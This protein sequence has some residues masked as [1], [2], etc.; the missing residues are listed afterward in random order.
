MEGKNSQR[1]ESEPNSYK[2][3]V[4]Y[5]EEAMDTEL[6]K[7]KK[8]QMVDL[9]TNHNHL[10]SI[11]EFKEIRAQLRYS[12]LKGNLNLIKILLSEATTQDIN[13]QF[14]KIDKTNKTA[15]LFKADQDLYHIVVPRTIKYEMNDHI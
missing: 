3:P 1:S 15:S 9:L 10:K 14:F 5:F 11:K 8:E 2:I 13:G 6:S 4:N 12:C 7:E